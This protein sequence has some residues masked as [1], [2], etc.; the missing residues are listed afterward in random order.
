MRMPGEVCPVH[1]QN[2]G[3]AVIVVVDERAAR[4]HGFGEPL[5]SESPIV[6]R[7]VNAGLRGDVLEMNLGLSISSQADDDEAEGYRKLKEFSG[8]EFSVA[9]CLCGKGVLHSISMLRQKL[10]GLRPTGQPRRLF[11]LGSL[12]APTRA[13]APAVSRCCLLDEAGDRGR[14]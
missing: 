4:P 11:L 7:E 8:H 12:R 6:M 13:H 5:P 14:L 1:Q 2:V 9:P 3:I 10:A